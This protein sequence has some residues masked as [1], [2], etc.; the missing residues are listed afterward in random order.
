MADVFGIYNQAGTL[1]LNM[2]AAATALLLDTWRTVTN[3]DGTV[4]ETFQLGLT[5]TDTTLRTAIE[6]LHRITKHVEEYF[7]DSTQINSFWLRA[8]SNGE[9]A[10]QALIYGFAATPVE[11]A[12]MTPLLGRGQQVMQIAIVRDEAWETIG[13]ATLDFRTVNCKGSFDE[14]DPVDTSTVYGSLDGRI[15][16]TIMKTGPSGASLY[17]LW[18]GIQPFYSTVTAARVSAHFHPIWEAEKGTALSGSFVNDA[19]ANP[20]GTS[21]NCLAVT[22]V[23]ASLTRVFVT[24]VLDHADSV[25]DMDVFLGEWYILGRIKVDAGTVGV[26]LRPGVYNSLAT[27]Y[28]EK[29]NE[30]VYVS[31]TSWRL[32]DLGRCRFP[33]YG[34]QPNT[35]TGISSHTLA[36]YLQQISGTTTSFKLDYLLLVPARSFVKAYKAYVDNTE[37]TIFYIR[38]DGK[39]D[40]LLEFEDGRPEATFINWEMPRNGGFYVMAA[41]RETSHELTDT[42]TLQFETFLRFR[43]HRG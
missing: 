42:I 18:C 5:G 33:I 36:V 41:E 16:R 35:V 9:T 34:V 39:E 8:Y 10:K 22:T 3:G 23:P 14:L 28:T 43:G 40:C 2:R 27:A 4:T 29:T 17:R 12:A 30:L 37:G 26:Q 24:D 38:E 25:N 13:S 6:L 32:I 21:S 1:V 19:T 20:A 31:N 7:E 11:E 15:N